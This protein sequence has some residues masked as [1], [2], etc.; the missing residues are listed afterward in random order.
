[1]KYHNSIA[2]PVADFGNPEE[3]GKVFAGFQKYL[4]AAAVGVARDRISALRLAGSALRKRLAIAR[5]FCQAPRVA[6]I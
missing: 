1:M 3:I 5:R 6:V 4:Y 2:D